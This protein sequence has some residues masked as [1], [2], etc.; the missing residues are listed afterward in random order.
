MVLD[1]SLPTQFTSSTIEIKVQPFP[2]HRREVQS[3]IDSGKI[4][5]HLKDFANFN[6]AIL[7]TLL[8][9]LPYELEESGNAS[10]LTPFL[11]GQSPRFAIRA[12][13]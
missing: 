9:T 11:A 1:L 10:V 2:K 7:Q 8:T 12:L 4:G 6:S 13:E 5:F 3:G